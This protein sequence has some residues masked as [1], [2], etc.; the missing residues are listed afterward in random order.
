MTR[1]LTLTGVAMLALLLSACTNPAPTAVNSSG[2]LPLGTAAPGFRLPNA[3]G[4]E[5]ALS[6]YAGQPVLLYFHMALG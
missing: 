3:H 6:D 2:G 4:G 1:L 5:V